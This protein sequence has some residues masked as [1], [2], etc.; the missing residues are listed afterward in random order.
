MTAMLKHAVLPAVLVLGLVGV[1]LGLR[2]WPPAAGADEKPAAKV[3]TDEPPKADE[4]SNAVGGQVLGPDGKPVA[5]ELILLRR[6]RD[7]GVARQGE[8]RRHVQRRRCRC[9]TTRTWSPARDGHGVGLPIR[10]VAARP[11]G[12]DVQAA[13]GQPG[14]RPGA[15]HAGQ[16]GRRGDRLPAAAGRLR[17]RGADVFLNHWKTRNP[18]H[19]PLHGET[20][21][22]PDPR[23]RLHP[24]RRAD[25]A[26]GEDGR[27]RQVRTPRAGGGAGG[28]PVRPRPRHRRRRGAWWSTGPRFDPTEVNRA[29]ADNR[30]RMVPKARSARTPPSRSCTGR[31][32]PSWRSRRR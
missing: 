19:G 5:A 31:P 3:E 20:D 18:Q 32:S 6:E 30:E 15:R 24:A 16:A 10:R 2:P 21:T 26:G 13:E 1:G 22:A 9:G 25:G 29:A 17:R 12:G 8:R 7:A 23:D 27:G 4:K 14:P 28:Q 11:G